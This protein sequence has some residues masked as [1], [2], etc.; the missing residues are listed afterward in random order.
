MRTLLL[1]DTRRA[2]A[3]VVLL[4]AA[5]A[6]VASSDDHDDG[7]ASP[8][9][10]ENGPWTLMESAAGTNLLLTGTSLSVARGV[11]TTLT[12]PAFVSDATITGNV[13]MEVSACVTGTNALPARLRVLLV[14]EQPV[15]GDA[16]EATVA[17]CPSSST[18][19]LSGLSFTGC[20]QSVDCA[21][22]YSAVFQRLEPSPAGDLSI[23]WSVTSEAVGYGSATP[24][25]GTVLSL[26]VEP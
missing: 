13:S 15:T 18:F 23:G 2:L 5:V 6:S 8:T 22:G 24:P 7:S 3:V 11:A 14:P 19:A 20:A 16:R 1:P 21:R 4:V 9:P 25:A 17:L 26:T 10:N 12:A